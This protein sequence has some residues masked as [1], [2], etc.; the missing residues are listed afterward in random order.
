MVAFGSAALL[1]AAGVICAAAIGGEVGQILA[2]AF[3]GIGLVA[4]ISLVFL[5]VGLSE[6]RE[7]ASAQRQ[8]TV[9]MNRPRPDRLGRRRDH[10]RRLG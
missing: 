4:V 8:L 6:D 10:P 7:R 2:F 5:E 3:I 1:V 9:R